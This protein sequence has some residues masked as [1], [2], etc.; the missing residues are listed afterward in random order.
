MEILRPLSPALPPSPFSQANAPSKDEG[1]ELR[2]WLTNCGPE[3]LA[4]IV[5]S[6][7]GVKS[8][9]RFMR[10]CARHAPP[11]NLQ[12]PFPGRF[13]DLRIIAR[14]AAYRF[15]CDRGRRRRRKRKAC[16]QANGHADLSSGARNPESFTHARR[17][18]LTGTDRG[19]NA[20]IMLITLKTINRVKLDRGMKLDYYRDVIT[21]R[22]WNRPVFV[23]YWKSWIVEIAESATSVKT[24]CA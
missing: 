3:P 2:G 15:N 13:L 5:Q 6:C 19:I 1:V 22:T 8:T 4:F 11:S 16:R 21:I 10:S 12:L 7:P 17:P 20:M 24:I 18:S 23:I 14:L 9:R